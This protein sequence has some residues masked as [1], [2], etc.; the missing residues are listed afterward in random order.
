MV[1]KRYSVIEEGFWEYRIFDD[2]IKGDLDDYGFE[3]KESALEK[4]KELNNQ[5]SKKSVYRQ[6]EIK[7]KTMQIADKI[8]ICISLVDI[9][10]EL[11]FEI[12]RNA[13][14]LKNFISNCK[15]CELS[16]IKIDSKN[17]IK[18]ITITE[19]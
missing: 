6:N 14:T 1:L 16:E 13:L 5:L 8:K 4:C 12:D 3:D 9:E 19:A 2:K 17:S 18:I 10:T 11:F 7:A 15:R